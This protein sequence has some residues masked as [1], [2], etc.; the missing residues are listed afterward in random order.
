M[1]TY[2]Q[3]SEIFDY[4][5]LF[6]EQMR[7]YY[8]ELYENTD[9]QRLRLFL[10]YLSQHEKNREGTL[11][12]YEKEASTKIMDT[13]FQYVPERYSLNLFKNLEINSDMSVDDVVN[14]TLRMNEFLVELYKG[15]IEETKIEEIKEVFN[16]KNGAGREKSCK[17]CIAFE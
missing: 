9:K 16:K 3:T 4:V 10:E 7:C 13:W 12:K 1:R 6:H 17:G 11:A 15:L 5:R 14:T 8:D 2:K